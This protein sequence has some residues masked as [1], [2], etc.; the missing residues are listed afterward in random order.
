MLGCAPSGVRVREGEASGRR[1]RGVRMLHHSGLG[2]ACGACVHKSWSTLQGW[3][4][5]AEHLK[6][7]GGA[8]GWLGA[9]GMLGMADV[10]GHSWMAGTW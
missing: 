4:G 8:P 5:A 6:M 1:G 10:P 7:R 9:A 3:A 2:F